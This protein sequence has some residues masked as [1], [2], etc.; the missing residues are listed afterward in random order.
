[1]LKGSDKRHSDSKEPVVSTALNFFNSGLKEEESRHPIK[2]FWLH[3]LFGKANKSSNVSLEEAVQYDEKAHPSKKS[4]GLML[5]NETDER[6]KAPKN[7]K[8]LKELESSEMLRIKT[9]GSSGR[10]PIETRLG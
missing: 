4:P 3:P 9:S 2:S 8:S 1:M 5:K 7:K 6:K 10:T